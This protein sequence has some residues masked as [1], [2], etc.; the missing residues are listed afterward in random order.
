MF[1]VRRVCASKRSSPLSIPRHGFDF[2]FDTKLP[3]VLSYLHTIGRQHSTAY[4]DTDSRHVVFQ[5]PNAGPAD[6][7]A[8][9][10]GMSIAVHCH[11]KDWLADGMQMRSN[12]SDLR[13]ASRLI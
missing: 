12:D 3:L 10:E 13:S 2:L 1:W 11:E 7:P 6:A 4:S 8:L 9:R 5:G